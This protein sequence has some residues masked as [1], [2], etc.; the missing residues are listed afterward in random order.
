M[1]PIQAARDAIRELSRRKDSGELTADQFREQSLPHARVIA[2][3]D[4][5][6][7]RRGFAGLIAFLESHPKIARELAA[8]VVIGLHECGF[9]FDSVR[10]QV[11]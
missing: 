4:A 10:R 7:S 11:S 2:E 5:E 6:K 3:A 1:D 8:G 9:D